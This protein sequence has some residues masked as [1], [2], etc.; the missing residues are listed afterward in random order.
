MERVNTPCLHLGANNSA[1]TR[2]GSHHAPLEAP[3]WT[4]VAAASVGEPAMVL[5]AAN[6]NPDPKKVV[7]PLDPNWVE[8]LLCKYS[9]I[10]T[11][12]HMIVG[13]RE[14]FDVGIRE[15]LSRLYIFPQSQFL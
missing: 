10:S 14:G 13:L 6:P 2:L 5:A 1:S 12:N 3:V 15:Q 8:E 4:F 7:T 9:L 11:W